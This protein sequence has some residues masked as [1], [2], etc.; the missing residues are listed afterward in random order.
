MNINAMGQSSLSGRYPASIAWTLTDQIVWGMRQ[1]FVAGTARGLLEMV[2]G[3][4]MVVLATRSLQDGS[5]GMAV[6]RY[7][8]R[9][10]LLV[11]VGLA[12]VLWL[13]W[14]ADFLH[15]YGLAAL[16]VFPLTRLRAGW[17]VASGAVY[18]AVLA[19]AGLATLSTGA[20]TSLGGVGG[21]IRHDVP[22]RLVPSLPLAGHTP[23]VAGDARVAIA[24]ENDERTSTR[25]RW[26]A[27]L[28]HVYATHF[29][30]GWVRYG[31][32][33]AG[34]TMLLGAGLFKWQV[35]QG[36]R[37]RIF[38]GR[39]GVTGYLLGLA[40]RVPG[41]W[42]LAN[43]TIPMPLVE[44]LGEVGRLSMTLGHVATVALLLNMP[45]GRALLAPFRAVG[46]MS[47]SVYLCQ[48]LL[49]LWLVFS[50]LGLGLY[51]R[52]TWAGL[53]VTAATI[54]LVLIVATNR[55]M[56]YYRVGPVEWIWRSLAASRALPMRAVRLPHGA[57]AVIG[58]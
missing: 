16:V 51:G 29:D 27:A 21:A 26:S 12:H 32:C 55:Y 7:Y 43:P 42:H 56:R 45:R 23:A 53:M 57:T 11:L 44:A 38:Y 14:F 50:P 25:V 35:L 5:L 20:P 28:V 6:R 18:A 47:L 49:A 19:I 4:G 39:L 36:A 48:T 15:I 46:R 30:W 58:R 9:S 41:A 13:G 8:V 34:A 37:S 17:L 3:A 22:S 52:M 1:V 31:L 40:I 10:L 2:F 24:A 33:E 54:D